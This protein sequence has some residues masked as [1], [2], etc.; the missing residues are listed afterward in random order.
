MGCSQNFGPSVRDYVTV[1]NILGSQ[2]STLILGTTH[3]RGVGTRG[4]V[5]SQF[6]RLFS[7]RGQRVERVRWEEPLCDI[8]PTNLRTK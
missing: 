8:G 7:L 2:D 3:I 1:P 4:L 6:F 5:P